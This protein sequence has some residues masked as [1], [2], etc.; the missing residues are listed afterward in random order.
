MQLLRD[1]PIFASG[2]LKVCPQLFLI[3]KAQIATRMKRLLM[4]AMLYVLAVVVYAQKD[5]TKF[6]G[7]PV[8]GTKPAMLQKLKAKGFTTSPY[9]KDVLTGEFNGHEVN[10]HVGTNN[11]KV[12]RIMVCDVNSVG[13]TDIRIR[14]NRLCQ[15]FS[16]NPKYIPALLTDY[17]ISESEDISY[18]ISV[19]DKRYE[20][21]FYQIGEEADSAFFSK[22]AYE[23]ITTQYT[24][25]QLS[26]STEEQRNEMMAAAMQYII[27]LYSKKPVWFM[28]SSYSGEYY[29]TMFYDNEYNRADGSD[30]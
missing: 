6:L 12:C 7:I 10:V 5:V 9:D 15:Q 3:L 29:I 24:Q 21:M 30:L 25:E 20:A 4:T 1:M 16:N 17:T 28:I 19:H 11:N 27:N 18:E 22:L 14:F 2:W 26:S 23:Y 8:D 13:E